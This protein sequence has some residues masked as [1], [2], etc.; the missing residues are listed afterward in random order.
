[1]EADFKK[2][3][4]SRIAELKA[5]EYLDR[6]QM[7]WIRYGLDSLDSLLPIWKIPSLVRSAPD[8]ITFDEDDNPLFIEAKAFRKI[9]KI[10]L[11]DM[12]NYNKWNNHL[13]ICFFLYDVINESSC[14]IMFNDLVAII[15]TKDPVISSYPEN[16]DNKFYEI[17]IGWLPDFTTF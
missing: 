15:K 6:R 3:N 2:R 4:V 14:M 1:M 9:V 13:G 12:K 5:I 17:E 8:Y 11:R 16:P 7:K 10:K